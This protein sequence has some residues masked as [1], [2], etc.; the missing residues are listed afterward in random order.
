M[1]FCDQK[2]RFWWC[3]FAA[4]AVVFSLTPSAAFVLIE[5]FETLDVGSLDG[6]AGWDRN[7][8]Q[9]NDVLVVSSPADPDFGSTR[10]ATHAVGVD[11]VGSTLRLD[12]TVA[13][14]IPLGSSGTV[15]FRVFLPEINTGNNHAIAFGVSDVNPPASVGSAVATLE[16]TGSTQF[17]PRFATDGGTRSGPGVA[18]VWGNYWLVFDN[19]GASG[20]QYDIYFST[21]TDDAPSIPRATFNTRRDVLGS[22][23]LDSLLISNASGV[24]SATQQAF[25]DDIYV[26]PT[27][28][29]LVN[30]VP[31]PSSILL[32]S[33]GTLLIPRRRARCA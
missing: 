33:G 8:L 7:P 5:N 13:E 17:Q 28:V 20:Q 11:A 31:E 15:F 14:A 3:A 21:G 18:G 32:V 10:S 25:I 23:A 27:S 24:E 2:N 4:S 30:P 9:G 1:R 19:T 16:S 12:L 22:A 26:D 6:Q 29:N